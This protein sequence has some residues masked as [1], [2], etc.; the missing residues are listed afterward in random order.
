VCSEDPFSCDNTWDG[1]CASSASE[2][3]DSGPPTGACCFPDGSCVQSTAADCQGD[4]QG[5]GTDCASTECPIAPTCPGDGDCCDPA[6]NGTPGCNDAACCELIC[7][8]DPFCCD[9]SWDG[10]CAG[11]ALEQCEGCFG[12]CYTSNGSAGCDDEACCNAVCAVD[13]FC[14]ETTWDGLC[15]SDAAELCFDAVCP[16]DTNGDLSVDVTDLTNVILAWGSTEFC[17]TGADVDPNGIVDVGD[18]T[19]VILNWGSCQGCGFPNAGPCGEANGTPYCD[20]EACCEAVCA[21]D[22]FCCDVEWDGLCAEEALELCGGPSEEGEPCG[23]DLNGGCNS[24]PPAFGSISCGE[25]ILGNA[26]A[27]GGSRDTDWYLVTTTDDCTTLTA[28]LNAAFEGV[29]FIVDGI[30][31]CEPVV[32]GEAGGNATP[33][34]ADVGPGSYVVFVAAAGFEGSPCGTTTGYDVTLECTP[35]PPG[36]Q[37]MKRSR[38]NL[39]ATSR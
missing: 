8:L 34:V 3:C 5:D 28:T 26:W 25:T 13:P 9:T 11:A 6:G 14:C 1:I 24:D 21:V 22:P 19:T 32:V 2:L 17:G 33:A 23:E 15:A 29:V 7:G 18:L 30:D 36:A 16:G 4:Y 12:C 37:M 35:C 27:D 20:D 39:S 31:T 10:V 38:G